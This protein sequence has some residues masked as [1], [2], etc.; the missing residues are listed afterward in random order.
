M[1]PKSAAPSCSHP[2]VRLI[3]HRGAMSGSDDIVCLSCR[4]VL[5]SSSGS[6]FGD[7]GMSNDVLDQAWF[8][9]VQ[10]C[11]HRPEC[12]TLFT[13]V[14]VPVT[15]KVLLANGKMAERHGTR[16]RPGIIPTNYC[17]RCGK[18]VQSAPPSTTTTETPNTPV[19]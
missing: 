14:T 3:V 19:S 13:P 17:N 2:Q 18:G 8:A 1:P 9:F 5:Y 16:T 11:T 6:V 4:K 15:K 10:D 7:D 12:F